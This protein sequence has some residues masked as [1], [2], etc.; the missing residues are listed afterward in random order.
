[1]SLGTLLNSG[2]NKLLPGNLSDTMPGVTSL[3]PF[4]TAPLNCA[5]QGLPHLP[6]VPGSLQQTSHLLFDTVCMSGASQCSAVCYCNYSLCPP[7]REPAE[8]SC[9]GFLTDLGRAETVHMYLPF[10]L[11]AFTRVSWKS[12][13]SWIAAA[14]AKIILPLFSSA[15]CRTQSM[16]IIPEGSYQL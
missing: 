8:K 11:I 16:C 3:S 5:L 12:W 15:A 2:I 1:M 13:P 14:H 9:A 6:L 10:S 4:A 7:P